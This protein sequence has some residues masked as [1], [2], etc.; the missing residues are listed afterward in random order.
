[1]LLIAGCDSDSMDPVEMTDQF[2]VTIENVGSGFP[3]LKHGVFN[4]PEG[5][6]NAGPL[7][8]GGAYEFSFSAGPAITPGS[9]TRLNFATMFVQS[10]DLYYAFPAEGLSLY[11]ADGSAVTGDVTSHLFLY[12]AGTEADQEP[13]VGSNQAPRQPAPDTGG[14]GEGIVVR[15]ADGASDDGFSYPNKADVIRVT[16]SHDGNTTFTV[17]VENVSTA[18]TLQTSEGGKPAVLSPGTYAVYGEGFQFHEVGAAASEGIEEIAEDGAPV[19]LNETLGTM[20]GVTVPLSPGAYAVHEAGF[21]LHAIGQAANAGIEAIAEDGVP[22]AAVAL[23]EA[24]DDV[25]DSGAFGPPPIAPGESFTFDIEAAPGDRLSFA[26][27]FVQSND[28]YYGFAPEGLAL[29]DA[30]GMP[31]SGDV[32]AQVALYDAGTEEDEEPGVGLNQV[33][34]QA[35]PDTGGPGE[36]AIVRIGNGGSDDGFTYR[37]NAEIIRVTITPR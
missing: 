4:T 26:T 16:L 31:I 8:P 32:T 22:D 12:D 13:G 36:G 17:R 19:T 35:A 21:Q 14:A 20:A 27:M 37:P 11:N 9:G 6:G 28:L 29:F 34:R 5:A 18:T 25:R 33:I 10:N 15:I 30:S 3:V 24:A 1:M 2:T 7:M 23:L